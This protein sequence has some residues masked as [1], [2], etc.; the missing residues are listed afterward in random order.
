MITRRQ[1]VLGGGAAT[2]ALASGAPAAA[3]PA[4]RS[5]GPAALG[6]PVLEAATPRKPKEQFWR[7]K[8]RIQ[9]SEAPGTIIINTSTKYL[10][11]VEGKN[12]ATRYGVGVGRDG[13]GWSGTVRVGRKAEW[14][15]WWPP[16]EMIA[17]E[18]RK[19]RILPEM[20]PGGEDNPL[21]ARALYLYK[22]GRDTIYRIHGTNQPWTIGQNMSSGCIRMM[23]EDVIHLYKRTPVGAKVIVIGPGGGGA[24][25]VYADL[26][27]DLIGSIFGG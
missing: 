8:V 4:M 6:L 26:G 12:R 1:F 20:M 14:P 11:F 15:D 18:R 2:L 21:G 9:T 3:F 24:E 22:G 5:A 23:N 25:K 10:Y 27:V 7:K 19:G 13:F 17:R 16:K